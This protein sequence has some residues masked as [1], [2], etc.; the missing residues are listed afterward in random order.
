MVLT[1]NGEVHTNEEAQ[2]FVPDL[3]LV[4]IVQ[5]LEETLAVLSLGKLCEDHGYSYEWFSGQK[6]RLTKEGKTTICKTDNFVPLVVP[7]LSTNSGSAS[8]STS[9]PQ[10][11]SSSSSSP[12]LERSDGIAPGNWFDPSKTQNTNKKRHDR[13]NSDIRLRDPPEW[14]EEFTDNLGDKE[15]PASAHSSQD[16]DSERPTK[17]VSKSRKRCVYTHFPKDRSCEVCLRT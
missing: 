6:P 2:V 3:N 12:V 13:K 4:G 16:S 14:L 17:A 7:G 5:L 1:A 8:F 11:S 10:D 15:L 9:P